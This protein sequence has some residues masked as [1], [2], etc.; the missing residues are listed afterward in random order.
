MSNMK[1]DKKG[2]TFMEILIVVTIIGVIVGIGIPNLIRAR[3]E[4]VEQICL[5]NIRVLQ[6]A[7][8]LARTQPGVDVTNLANDAALSPIVVPT[9]MLSMPDCPFGNFSTDGNGDVHCSQHAP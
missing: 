9:Y 2:F 5:S 7:V 1:L 6:T 8:E 4:T 3:Q